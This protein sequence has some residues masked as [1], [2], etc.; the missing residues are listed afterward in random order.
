MEGC[1]YRDLYDE[2]EALGVQIVGVSFADL[3]TLRDWADSEGFQ[4]ELWSDDNKDLAIYYGAGTA[5][6]WAPDRVTVV[7]DAEGNQLLSYSV[8]WGISSHPR[9]VLEDVQAIFGD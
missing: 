7:L 9:E 3:S 4:Y 8:G 5:S 6:S 2:F 1:G